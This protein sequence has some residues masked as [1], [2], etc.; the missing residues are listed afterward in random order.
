VESS[1]PLLE[2]AA[3]QYPQVWSRSSAW[4]DQG[5]LCAGRG[6]TQ[7]AVRALGAALDAYEEMGAEHDA[8]RVRSWLRDMGVHRSHWRRV[9]RPV[10][11]W[12]S[13]TDTELRVAAIVAEGLTN[14]QVAE[15]L[16]VSRHTVDFHL[17]Q[18]FRKLAVRSR[19][20][21]A[22]VLLEQKSTGAPV[23]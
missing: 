1:P 23:Q 12:Q 6:E 5:V 4:E 21:L 2:A 16:F 18:I 11:G 20:E 3:E 19:T 10:C 13:L 22:R 7:E 17:R 8:A 14:A 9:E 15:R